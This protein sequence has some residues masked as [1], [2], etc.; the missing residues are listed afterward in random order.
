MY[1]SGLKEAL[2][3]YIFHPKNF[4]KFNKDWKLDGFE[5]E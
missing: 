5:S 2:I 4:H 1:N 3:K